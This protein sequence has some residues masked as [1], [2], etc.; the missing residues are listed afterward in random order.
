MSA[1]YSTAALEE[2][3]REL[4]MQPGVYQFLDEHDKLLYIGKATK[5]RS[6][7]QSYFRTSTDLTAA[8]KRM[9]ERIRS[10]EVIIV[11]TEPE[12]LLLETTLIKKYKPPY[13]VVMKDD[14]NFQYIHLTDDPFPQIEIARR[15]HH[16]VGGRYLRKTGDY[17]GPYTS[18]YA[19]KKTLRLLKS[20]FGYC[21]SPPIMKRGEIV[22]PERPCLEYHL[23]RCV[24][25]CA[26]A[27]TPEEYQL[28]FDQIRTFLKGEYEPVKKELEA[29]MQL[30]SKHQQYETAARLRDQ[31]EAISK[32][33]AEQKII[34]T[35]RENADFLSL[36]RMDNTAAVNL[37]MVRRGKLLHQEVLLLKNAKEATDKELLDAF[38]D[39]YYAQAID[40]PPKIVLSSETRRG[41]NRRL[42]EMG[43]KN[44]EEA[45]QRNLNSVQKHDKKARE[46]LEQ[47]GAAI[48][49]PAEKLGRIET[50]DISNN[51]GAFTV[52]SMVV[53]VDGQPASAEYRK[54]KIKTVEGPNDFA[55]MK[56]VLNRRLRHIPSRVEKRRERAAK[57]GDLPDPWPQPDLIIIDGGKG[58]LR[59]AK[60]IL[61]LYELD[62]PI[63]SLAKR[64]EE[65]FL[66]GQSESVLL[67][68]DSEGLYLIQRMRDEAHRF[69]IGFYRSRHL[70]SLV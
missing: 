35:K 40:Q 69:A 10:V 39:Q 67:D 13:N 29:Q 63:I 32:L 5:L 23:G 51:Q 4:P 36:A 70:K 30:A 56:E 22:Y 42:L 31:I 8:K 26:K 1:N 59:A 50:Y 41:R 27:I 45:L 54:F 65:I 9:V 15:I 46:G 57:D 16:K 11:D 34:S 43:M 64:Q 6:R 68:R 49:I 55:S 25:P 24:G 58:Q 53:F 19:V 62:I 21:T 28:L 2:M 60:T 52:A 38:V 33:M 20:I 18:G 7:V 3:V 17:F 12:A 61:D 37:F 66:P 48:G 47:L 14:K 44:A